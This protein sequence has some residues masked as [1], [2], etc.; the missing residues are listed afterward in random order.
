MFKYRKM[1][2][3]EYLL[4]SYLISATMCLLPNRR[5]REFIEC[6]IKFDIHIDEGGMYYCYFLRMGKLKFG[7]VKLHSKATQP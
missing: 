5:S 4:I 1:K 6:N 7:K 3:K 2:K